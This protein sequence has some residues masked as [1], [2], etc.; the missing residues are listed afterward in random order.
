MKARKELDQR[1]KDLERLSNRLLA[2]KKL[3]NNTYLIEFFELDKNVPELTAKE[4][5]SVI[6]KETFPVI[7][8]LYSSDDNLL[9][10]AE[11]VNEE[12][13]DTNSLLKCFEFKGRFEIEKSAEYVL[14]WNSKIQEEAV[15]IAYDSKM[16]RFVCGTDI[17][18]IYILNVSNPDV[19]NS[20]APCHSLS[21]TSISF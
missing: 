4:C 2:K 7:S 1:K 12:E 9:I 5:R 19:L 13:E 14:K 16:K 3:Y 18:L 10:M 21:V 15:C 8:F 20:S 17:G 6:P 11:K